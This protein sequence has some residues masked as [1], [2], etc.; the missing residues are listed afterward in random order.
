VIRLRNLT[1]T[2]RLDG[3]AKT[4]IRQANLE[5]PA[6][7]SVGL[8]GRNGAGK[9][10]LLRLIAGTQVPTSGEIIIDG[11]VSWP[12]GFAGSFHADLTGAQNTRYVARIY[13]VDSNELVSFTEDFAELGPH[14]NLPLRSYSSGMISRLAFAV[15]MGISFDFYLVDEITAVGDAAFRK[16][17]NDL[18]LSRMSSAGAIVVNHTMSV[19]RNLCTKAMVLDD[20]QLHWFDDVDEAIRF[21]NDLMLK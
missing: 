2:Y 17:S 18:F 1:K 21:H 12:V 8:L 13:G 9:S 16:K 14:F 5:I 11:T 6:Q 20:G 3:V 7:T 10:T 15:S 19:I 4:V